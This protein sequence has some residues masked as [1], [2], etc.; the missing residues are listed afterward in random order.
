VNRLEAGG[1]KADATPRVIQETAATALVDGDN[2]LGHL[3]MHLAAKTAIE[4]A[5]A[6]GIGWVGVRGNNHAGPLALYVQPM[7]DHGMAGLAG[8]VGSA[9]HVPP[10]GGNELL[11]GTNP[12]AVAVPASGRAPF[13]L[14]MATTVASAGKIKTLAQRGEMMPEGWMVG[15][16]GKPL[17]DPKRQSE[18]FLLPIG[19]AK[20]YGLALAI[21]LLAGAL[22]GA[23]MGRDVVDFTNDTA[24]PANTGQFVAAIRLSAFGDS[25]QI[26]T[27][28]AAFCA[29]LEASGTLP[30]H[31]K[32]RVPGAARE[33]LYNERRRQGLV[34]HKN[35]A[36]EL[37]KIANARGLARLSQAS[38]R[39]TP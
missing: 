14:D 7:V 21:A 9:N 37:D 3:A 11:L 36:S 34:L 12:L 19:G 27:A 6:A 17:T 10:Y 29:D 8:G 31:D 35:L 24:T 30:G 39:R 26:A 2:G 5:E 23:A 15:P 38:P 1:T 22:N 20:G 4:K 33:T 32:V 28:A 16:D 25:A 13:L 18:G